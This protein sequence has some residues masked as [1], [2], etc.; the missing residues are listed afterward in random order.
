MQWLLAVGAEKQ[1]DFEKKKAERAARREGGEAVRGPDPQPPPAE[2]DAKDQHNFTDPGSRIMKAG[3]GGHFEQACNAQ[4]AVDTEGN[5]LVLG[6]YVT[7]APNDKQQLKPA[8]DCVPK[9]VRKTT[10]VLADTGYHSDA[11]VAAVEADGGPTVYA[12]VEKTGYHRTVG[13]LPAQPAPEEPPPGLSGK[14]AMRLRLRTAS[15]RAA[16]KKRKE[17]VE[18]F[19]GIVKAAMGFRR[20]LLRG[21]KK[22]NLEWCL[23]RVACNFRRLATLL[24]A[25]EGP[26]RAPVVP[27]TA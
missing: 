17:T 5:M 20:F 12:A 7:D 6:G 8:V 18:P 13:D 25:K 26:D 21:L 9:A 3:N 22:V 10:Q 19:F 11:A 1:G 14:D 16:C 15:G 24:A 2:P 27:A 23:V 4:A